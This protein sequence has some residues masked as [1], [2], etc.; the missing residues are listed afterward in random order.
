MTASWPRTHRQ[1]EKH[2]GFPRPAL[3][4]A[5]LIQLGACYDLS[6]PECSPSAASRF[7]RFKPVVGGPLGK[8]AR[9]TYFYCRRCELLYEF[10]DGRLTVRPVPRNEIKAIR[11][12]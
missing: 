6:V 9:C 11:G 12:R 5:E 7:R 8:A 3:C 2:F 10:R 1:L 4:I